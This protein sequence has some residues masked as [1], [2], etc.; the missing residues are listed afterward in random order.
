MAVSRLSDADWR[1]RF[2]LSGAYP[3]THCPATAPKSKRLLPAYRK[4]PLS[5]RSGVGYL[6]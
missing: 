1:E 4:E 5:N 3:G 6:L 2:A